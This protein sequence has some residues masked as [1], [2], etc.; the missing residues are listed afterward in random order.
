MLRSAENHFTTEDTEFFSVISVPPWLIF[1]P[2]GGPQA[3]VTLSI[4]ALRLKVSGEE[5]EAKSER[6][7]LPSAVVH[8]KLESR[9]SREE[10]VDLAQALGQRVGSQQRIIAFAQVLVVH[11]EIQRQ[12]VHGNGIGKGGQQVL[13]LGFLSLRSRGGCD[14]TQLVGVK[15]G[16][17]ASFLVHLLPHQVGE[18]LR[19]ANPLHEVVSHVDE[20]LE[21]NGEAVFH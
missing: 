10:F 2:T 9:I 13:V 20:E 6:P 3:N 16:L 18:L 4:T 12:R 19:N 15:R 17:A 1:I 8:G 14:F 11:I 7:L 21:R 5:R